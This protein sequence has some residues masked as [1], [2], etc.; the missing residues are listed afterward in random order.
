M[1]RS[2]P[3]PA[4]RSARRSRRAE[5]AR[6]AAPAVFLAAFTIAVVL[7]RAGLN[8]GDGGG[9]SFA[10]STPSTTVPTTPT[11][12]GATKTRRPKKQYYVIRTGDTFGT[13][14]AKFNTSVEALQALNPGVS[15]NSLSVGQ[16]IRVK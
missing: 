14:A 8:S 9:T 3:R 11:T 6:Y 10:L 15:S 16:R 5:V 2:G 4:G 13:V 7:V 12:T 1:A